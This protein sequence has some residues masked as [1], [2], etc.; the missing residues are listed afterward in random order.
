VIFLK[1]PKGPASPVITPATLPTEAPAT[2][3]KSLSASVILLE[4]G[5]FIQYW[6]PVLEK[7]HWARLDTATLSVFF[8]R[9][10][11]A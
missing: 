1:V 10:P 4:S 7:Y 5:R 8:M 9:I 3:D 6:V 11:L 2:S